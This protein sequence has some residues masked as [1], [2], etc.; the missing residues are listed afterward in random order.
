MKRK[1]IIAPICASAVLALISMAAVGGEGHRGHGNWF[2]KLDADGNG[3][4]SQAEIN[5][6]GDTHF[7]K[8]DNDGDGMLSKQEF[9]ARKLSMLNKAD[10]DGNGE[11][12]KD[13]WAAA[14]QKMRAH[15]DSKKR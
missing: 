9:N 4:I 3:S 14:K 7:N 6:A 15:R 8:L 1:V 11:I 5:A 12:S 10:A 2:E 13:E